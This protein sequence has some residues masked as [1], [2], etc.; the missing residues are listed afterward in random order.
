MLIYKWRWDCLVFANERLHKSMLI[1]TIS[2]KIDIWQ[3]WHIHITV[4]YSIFLEQ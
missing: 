2:G 1:S 3:P 4:P